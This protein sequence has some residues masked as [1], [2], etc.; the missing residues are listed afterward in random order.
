MFR[1]R[2]WMTAQSSSFSWMLVGSPGMGNLA[3][4]VPP[5]PT[6]Q[7]GTATAKLLI[8]SLTV[9]MATPRRPSMRPRLSYSSFSASSRRWFSAS[10]NSRGMVASVMLDSLWAF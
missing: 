7:L 10:I 1:P 6:P 9:S 8:F 4:R 5:T 3:K 2:A